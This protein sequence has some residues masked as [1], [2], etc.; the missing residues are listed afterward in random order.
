MLFGNLGQ[1]SGG[2]ARQ[3]QASRGPRRGR[4]NEQS[5]EIS[6]EDAFKGSTVSL[7]WEGGRQIEARIPPGV[8]TGSRVRLSGQGEAGGGG[9]PAGD[10]YLKIQ[11]K[12]HGSFK[13]EGDDLHVSVPIDLY[14]ALLG[15]KVYV[16]T[17][18][19]PVELTVPAET[20]NGKV[21]RLRGLGMPKLHEP[22]VRGNLYATVEVQLPKR[23]SQEERQLFEKL[24]TMRKSS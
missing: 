9:G 21:F 6:L 17:L 19:R 13:R 12:P 11:V 23:L 4:D 20:P 24:R 1:R 18:E 14:T 22:Q 5:L 16:P 3:G 2:A 8:Q 7:R 15:G 10:L